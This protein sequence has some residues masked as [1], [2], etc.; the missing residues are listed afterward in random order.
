[1]FL[2]G[3]GWSLERLMPLTSL[4]PGGSRHKFIWADNNKY[5]NHTCS[6]LSPKTR[7]CE[8]ESIWFPWW[9]LYYY[10]T[11]GMAE[12]HCG[13]Q[14]KSWHKSEWGLQYLPGGSGRCMTS[15]KGSPLL[16]TTDALWAWSSVISDLF[17]ML[18]SRCQPPLQKIGCSLW[19][20]SQSKTS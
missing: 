8:N 19:K 20:S 6:S 5:R 1:M 10:V 14:E 15:P 13:P 9:G 2:K 17:P 7:V 16:M 18:C 11:Y 4:H 12:G 3:E